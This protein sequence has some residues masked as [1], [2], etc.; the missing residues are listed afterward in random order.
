MDDKQRR[1]KWSA[2]FYE[3]QY[4]Y[5]DEMPPIVKQFG[6]QD[7]IC[8]DT[9]RKHRQAWLLTSQ[10][11]FTALQKKIPGVHLKP[12]LTEEHWTRLKA[13]CKKEESKDPNGQTREQVDN[14]KYMRQCDIYM[15]IAKYAKGYLTA[16]SI[17]EMLKLKMNPYKEEFWYGANR[18]IQTKKELVCFLSSAQAEKVWTKTRSTWFNLYNQSINEA[19]QSSSPSQPPQEDRTQGEGSH[20]EPE[21]ASKGNSIPSGGD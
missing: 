1:T 6:W 3:G 13:Y 4:H 21:A 19:E 17:T 15:L 5:L 8:P 9:G 10:Q 12:V 16:E 11:S 14:D 20:Q 7:E 18:I 2:T